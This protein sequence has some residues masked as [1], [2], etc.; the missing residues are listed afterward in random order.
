LRDQYD[1]YPSKSVIV[2]WI[3]KYTEIAQKAL[4]QYKPHVSDKWMVTEDIVKLNKKRVH[5]LDIIDCRTRYILSTDIILETTEAS[6]EKL[7]NQAIDIGGIKPAVINWNSALL[8]PDSRRIYHIPDY[9]LESIQFVNNLRFNRSDYEP[10]IPIE[11][12]KI[13]AGLRSTQSA[14]QFLLRY[15]IHYNHFRP[16][17]AL[18]GKTPAKAAGIEHPFKTWAD[19]INKISPPKNT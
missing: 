7:L 9:M 10:Y 1:Y 13:L 11:R 8:N 16:N 18:G 2:K 6:I 17:D 14:N 3:C 19:I 12:N 4:S 15:N 5:V